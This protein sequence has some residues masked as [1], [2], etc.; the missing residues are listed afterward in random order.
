MYALKTVLRADGVELGGV[1]FVSDVG[2]YYVESL[3]FLER[4][5]GEVVAHSDLVANGV[6]VIP[7]FEELLVEI[8]KMLH[9]FL[10]LGHNEA[11]G[12]SRNLKHAV[13]EESQFVGLAGRSNGIVNK[14]NRGIH[15]VVLAKHTAG[16]SNCELTSGWVSLHCYFH[17]LR[18]YV[19]DTADF[20]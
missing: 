6:Y 2:P 5:R 4:E 19:H 3:G 12:H 8:Y 18:L 10:C 20:A 17:S 16:R 9:D 13:A 11:V 15:L 7:A 14:L 1:V